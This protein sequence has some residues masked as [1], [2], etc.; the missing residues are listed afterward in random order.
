[1]EVLHWLPLLL[2]HG[3]WSQG[4]KA[5]RAAGKRFDWTIERVSISI[6]SDTTYHDQHMELER[7]KFLQKTFNA[8]LE[9][10]KLFGIIDERIIQHNS[11]QNF[12]EV[13]KV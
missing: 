9:L 7:S 8:S 3:N 12:F 5:G 13:R 6:F 1:L 10:R 11:L 2:C 4:S